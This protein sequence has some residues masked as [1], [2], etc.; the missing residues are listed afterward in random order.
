MI[1]DDVFRPLVRE[2]REPPVWM[3]P[4]LVG[5]P[6]RA[7][8]FGAVGLAGVVGGFALTAMTSGGQPLPNV[9]TWA[10]IAAVIPGGLCIAI[11]IDESRRPLRRLGART[12]GRGMRR[13]GDPSWHPR[14]AGPVDEYRRTTQLNEAQSPALLLREMF[15]ACVNARLVFGDAPFR[16]G[17]AARMTFTASA[18]RRTID[19]KRTSFHLRCFEEA[20]GV[21]LPW[22]GGV[23][24]VAELTPSRRR[25]SCGST[26]TSELEFG[27]PQVV[28]ASDLGA[29]AP[30]Y[31]ILS[32][33]IGGLDG[34]YREEFYVPV[35]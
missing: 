11:C 26:F 14:I 12:F 27:V 33:A 25:D 3:R 13:E 30:R 34:P 23:R 5:R 28:P 6:L 10:S 21:V 7:A 29:P 8:A 35:A 15:S 16:R 4:R 31:W 9:W 22:R 2:D 18:K 19:G 20:P 24:C 17:A 1:P 32:A